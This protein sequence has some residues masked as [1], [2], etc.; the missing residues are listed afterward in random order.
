MKK[1]ILFTMLILSMLLA[2]CSGGRKT[3]TVEPAAASPTEQLADPTVAPVETASVEVDSLIADTWMWIGFTDPTQQYSL[4][5]PE[6]YTLAFQTDGTVNIKADCNNAIGAYTV[7]GSSIQIEVGP[8]TMAAC[9]PESLSEQFIEHLGYAAIYF[10]EDGNLFIDLFADGGTMEFAPASET[11]MAEPSSGSQA[12]NL[13]RHEPLE[14]CFTAPPE[15]TEVPVEYDCGYVVVP[16]FYQGESTRELKVPFI[17][18]NS[19]KGTAVSPVLVHPGGPGASQLNEFVFPLVTKMFSGVITERDVIFMDPRGTEFSE[20]FLD[21]PAI[22]SLSWK[23]YEQGLDDEAAKALFTETVQQCI[24]DFK[25]QGI[26]FDAYNSLELAGDVN[27]VREALGYEQIIY[28]GM[29]YGSQLGQ[30]VM[31]D[32][33]EML[34]AVI[35]DGANA[36]SRKSWIEDRALDDQFGIDN[37]TKLCAADEKCIEAY[38][39]IPAMVEAAL[40]LFDN[41]P[42]PYTYTDPN[43]PSL[44]IA[45]E[46]T[47]TDL[48]NLLYGYQGDKNNVYII[49]AVLASMTEPGHIENLTAMLGERSAKNIIASRELTKGGDAFLMHLAV[50]CSD[51]P[52]KSLDDIILDGAGEYARL[53]AQSA[54]ELYN[55]AAL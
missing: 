29:S 27:S 51:D 6:S 34:E 45:G 8:M 10:F 25:A 36:L 16:E 43:N 28:Y 2:A 5:Q 7:D 12:G 30:H 24:D 42:L 13:P 35:L 33:P 31:R 22:Y 17:R 49:P 14:E 41:G 37:L 53:H 44:S 55:S 20:T 32:Y 40:R 26:N 46:V 47:A 3:A 1:S 15:G 48:A 19:G 9:P 21:C 52:V 11:G 38:P 18:F 4:D 23:A 54:A 50:V 39:D